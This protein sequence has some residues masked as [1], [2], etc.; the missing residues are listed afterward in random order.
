[1]EFSLMNLLHYG[2]IYLII[3][4]IVGN[5]IDYNLK[6]MYEPTSFTFSEMIITIVLWPAVIIIS[7]FQLLNDK[8]V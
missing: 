1:M 6:R 5:L 4:I 7:I 2:S 3:G 8:D